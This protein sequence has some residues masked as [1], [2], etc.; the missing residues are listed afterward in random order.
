MQILHEELP[1]AREGQLV[2]VGRKGRIG[3][4]G[5]GARQ[6]EGRGLARCA[7]CARGVH[8]VQIAVIRKR[9]AR[10]IVRDVEI[11]DTFRRL[12]ILL[13]PLVLLGRRAVDGVFDRLQIR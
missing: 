9:G 11:A 3:F 1:I 4:G 2:S 5:L 10:A 6:P 12:Q 13:L 7:R 8:Q